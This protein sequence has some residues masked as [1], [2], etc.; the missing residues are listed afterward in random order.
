MAAQRLPRGT[1]QKPVRL[2]WAIEERKKQRLEA[3]AAHAGVS[4]AVF[5]ERLIDHVDTELNDRGLPT[6]WPEQQPRDGELPIDT[7]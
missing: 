5:L 2:G 1:R 7:A 4:G 6:W 3:L